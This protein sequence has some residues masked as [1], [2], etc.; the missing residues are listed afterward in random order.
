[1]T[2]CFASR[3][4]EDNRRPRLHWT[5][6][7]HA[8][9]HNWGQFLPDGQHFLYYQRASD[10]NFQGIFVG[11]LG[12]N[13]HSARVLP[14]DGMA[15]YAHG[16]L[17]YVRDG[18]LFV[19]PFD[20]HKFIVTGE[21]VRIADHVGY[22]TGAFGYSGIAAAG[23]LLAYGPAVDWTTSLQ[24]RTRD[25]RML[26]RLGSPGIYSS[27][28]L[29]LDQKLVAVAMSGE[30]M[31][32]RDVWT[33]DVARNVPSKLTSDPS[34]DWFPV[35]A[36]DAGHIYFGSSRLGITNVFEKI[37]VDP[38]QKLEKTEARF[39]TYPGDVSSDGRLLVCT[40]STTTGYDL[41]VTTLADQRR[42]D[43]FL[44]TRFNEAQPR[45]A[46]NGRWIAYTSDESG[47]FEVY[48]RP[49]PT[50]TE[51]KRISLAGGMQPE[52]RRDGREL[53][54]IAADGKMMAVPVSTTGAAFEPGTPTALFDV[55]VPEPT[56]PYPTHYAVTAD[57]QRFLVN[58]VIDQ[59]TRPALT[60]I[61]NWTGL[62]KK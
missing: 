20:D 16:H 47:Q 55:E 31:A 8:I 5:Q 4:T 30:T 25:G 52:W 39:A 7:K 28:R 12:Q 26:D 10:P 33:I 48:V 51:Q 62:L 53:F 35:W 23:N 38:D 56:A 46:P 42:T 34:A 2:A 45:F 54:Y 21:S 3:P 13:S 24:W 15:I 27:P 36:P 14:I 58:T 50:A 61:L 40:Q 29:A 19:Q 57:G 60:V 59:P 17:A 43:P 41:V 11:A 9:G 6:P 32:E 22:F 44:V 49:Y 37:G 1:M 18:V